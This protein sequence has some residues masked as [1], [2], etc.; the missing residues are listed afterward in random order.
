MEDN[1]RFEE[2]FRAVKEDFNNGKIELVFMRHE[3]ERANVPKQVIDQFI[4]ANFNH[5]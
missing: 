1:V 3:L 5:L 2:V 4:R